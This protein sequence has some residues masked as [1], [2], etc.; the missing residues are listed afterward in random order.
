MSTSRDDTAVLI[1]AVLVILALLGGGV[2]FIGQRAASFRAMAVAQRAQAM[3]MEARVRAETARAEEE[4]LR[5]AAVSG[6]VNDAL[7]GAPDDQ[8]LSL[9]EAL[10]RAASKLA[11]GSITDPAAAA[12]IHAALGQSYL[13]LK[14]LDAAERHFK[15]ALD[16]HTKALGPT[17][18]EVAKDRENLDSIARAR[19]K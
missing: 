13:G 9:R 11:D 18:T 1:V 12:S 6:S 4:S 19:A 15:A 17:S 7:A 10:D 3:E 16:L 5:A 8:A 14:D 2:L